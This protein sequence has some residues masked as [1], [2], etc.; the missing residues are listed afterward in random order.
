MSTVK[1]IE[2]EVE[3]DARHEMTVRL[4]AD[5]SLGRHAVVIVLDET[6]PVGPQSGSLDDFPVDSVRRWPAG[7]SLR[8]E[9]LYGDAGR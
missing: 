2:A 1:T 7:L 4:P 6:L 5:V 9:D 3:V 8:R